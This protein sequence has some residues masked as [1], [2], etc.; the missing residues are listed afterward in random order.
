M[1]EAEE[2]QQIQ[3]QR[4]TSKVRQVPNYRQFLKNSGNK[5]S[6][7]NFIC[8]HVCE[9]VGDKLPTGTSIVLAGGFSEGEVVK[10]VTETG[11][12][13]LDNLFS[14]QEEADTR[15]LLHAVYL[16]DHSRIIIRCDDTDVLVLLIYYWS[17]GLLSPEVY[18]HAGHSQKLVS[19]ERYIS[20]HEI[21]TPLGPDMCGCLPAMHAITGCDTTCAMYRIGKRTAYSTLSKNIDILNNL[22]Q[23][24]TTDTEAC[25]E[26]ARQLVLLML[27]KKARTLGPSDTL[28]DLRFLWATTTDKPASMLPPTE[29]AFKQHVLRAIYQVKIWCN[30]HIAK[31]EPIDPVGHGWDRNKDGDLQTTKFTKDSAPIEVRDITHLYCTDKDCTNPAKCPCTL[32][33]LE[34]LDICSCKGDCENPKNKKR[35]DNEPETNE[36]QET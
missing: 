36:D 9:N 16:S 34:C 20:V 29:D 32:A 24:H 25:I 10:H 17:K 21:A 19:S 33:S 13:P 1:K 7:A 15:I 4:M 6:L 11:V 35:D 26:S 3:W 14:L 30:S 22:Q 31:S 23:F 8:Q 12:S 5:A 27:G 18:M 28:D 2:A